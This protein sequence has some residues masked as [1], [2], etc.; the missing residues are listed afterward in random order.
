MAKN[1]R[2]ALKHLKS[3]HK[4][5]KLDEKKQM[6]NEI[7]T[8]NMSGVYSKNPA[9]FRYDPPSPAKRFVP[10]IDG[11]WPSGVPGTP[12]AT[13]YIRPQGYWV[14]DSDWDEFLVP[15]LRVD[16]TESTTNT[17]GFINPET[18]TVK[19]LLPPNSRDFILGPLIDGYTYNHGY[20][21]FTT[22]GYIQK[23]T[24]QIVV[25]GQI[26]GHWDTTSTLP[27]GG[28]ANR[29][30]DG[31]ASQF[32]AYNPKFTLAMAQ[33]FKDKLTAND[34]TKNF[35]YF[36]S[37]GVPQSPLDPQPP[38]SPGNMPGGNV[39]GSGGGGNDP[40]G[41]PPTGTPTG[42]SGGSPDTGSE[43]P[44]GDP[45]G[46][47]PGG[48]NLWGM[49]Q[50][51]ARSKYGHLS[52]EELAELGIVRMPDGTLREMT[53]EELKAERERQMHESARKA[54][55]KIARLAGISHRKLKNIFDTISPIGKML[56][57]LIKGDS[58]VAA[59][60]RLLDPLARAAGKFAGRRAFGGKLETA[61]NVMFRYD[62]W[63]SSGGKKRVDVSNEVSAKE[64]KVLQNELHKPLGKSTDWWLDYYQNK[65][66]PGK[67]DYASSPEE[68]LKI[69]AKYIQTKIDQNM[70]KSGTGL[71]M[72]FHNNVKLD[73]GRY[74]ASGGKDIQM[75]KT[76]KF[77]S[78]GSVGDA[79][80][81]V[82][83]Q[84]LIG[85]GVE[86][87]RFGTG[88]IAK[89]M[90]AIIGSKY[91][92]RNVNRMYGGKAYAAPGMPMRLKVPSPGNVNESIGSF[93]AF[94]NSIDDNCDFL[95]EDKKPIISED[96]KRIIREI[97]QPLKE[98][99][100]LP[101][102]QKLEKYRPNFKGKYK[103]QNTPNVTASKKSDEMVKAKNAAGQTWRTKD[104]YWGGYESQE[105]M[106]VVYDNVGHGDQYWDKI[107]NENLSKRDIKN[108][109]IQEHM[110]IIE[111]EKAMRRLDS[112]FVSPFRN[113]EEQE[114]LDAPKDPLYKKVAK[115]LDKEID[116]PKKPSPKGFPDKAPPELD[117][118]TGMH[119]KYGQRYK[120]D[121][122]D[123]QSAEAM[124][125]QGNPEIDANVQKALD[126][127][128]KDRKVKNLTVNTTNK[129]VD[130]R[131]T[132][133][134]RNVGE[135]KKNF[136][137]L[138][139]QVYTNITTGMKVGQTF[140][141][142]PS[143]QTFTTG[144]ALGGR[145][146][147]PSTVSIFG[148]PTPAP[149]ASSYPLQGYAKPMDMM[150]RKNRENPEDINARLD[151][152]QEFAQ[153]VNSDVMMN[154]RVSD[155]T[156]YDPET[157]RSPKVISTDDEKFLNK[158]Q[159]LVN[160]TKGLG[161]IGLPNDFAQWTIN[162][163]KGDMKPVTKFST[164][165]ERQVRDLVLD[166]FKK[167][168]DATTVDIQYDDYGF[169]AKALPTRLGLG[170]FTATKLDNGK[171]RI[172][173][174]FN[175]DKEFT[176]IGFADIIPGLQ[177][178]ADRLVDI[179]YK[180]RNIKG[181]TDKGGI[182]IDVEIKGDDVIPKYQ[183]NRNK[184]KYTPQQIKNAADR[185]VSV[186]ALV[187]S[188]NR[189][190]EAG[191]GGGLD[192]KAEG[193][194]KSGNWS[195]S[196]YIDRMNEINAAA[197]KKSGPLHK[198]LRELPVDNRPNRGPSK[199]SLALVNA[200]EKI[201]LATDKQLNALWNAWTEYNKIEE[202]PDPKS[203]SGS[204]SEP[205]PDPKGKKKGG[206]GGRRLG[207]TTQRQGGAY[208]PRNPYGTGLD[209][210]VAPVTKKRKKGK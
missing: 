191:K 64:M 78:G 155:M 176:N 38:G 10:D 4:T 94:L 205:P 95:M 89:T 60:D 160:L 101:K 1:F 143:G 150:R 103:A 93:T 49:T 151:A 207:S 170:R 131:E 186:E 67:I 110:N 134:K 210:S 43:T 206:Q 85:M 168:P 158:Q 109:R 24:R 102:T 27:G 152:S 106:N 130:W 13:E 39:P 44:Q 16:F 161:E 163:A 188:Q 17:D 179:S 142:I 63:L 146:T 83:G 57:D 90:T 144:G 135:S 87:D 23:D 6:L 76:Y 46:T 156:N 3:N 34:F 133:Q 82:L 70:T 100:E 173:D 62:K 77:A 182:K 153:N 201:T 47:D 36:Y 171:I 22:I 132:L 73:M 184:S 149:D 61:S 113:I 48:N 79:E 15:D 196:D 202:L 35:P 68:A 104:K 125:V 119:P 26:S 12:G 123:P 30:W 145:E 92:L 59:I 58:G 204:G 28:T 115:R 200:I 52:N 194:I 84:L 33:W 75:T 183:Q 91:G 14:N 72:T 32:T 111:H 136:K 165:M 114:T 8:M 31:T 41:G 25:L 81:T 50:D 148:D 192:S 185:H 159:T 108:R 107:V 29:Q 180:N 175:V 120:Y 193:L 154:A 97:T 37:G 172:Q 122:L 178:T 7:P 137:D 198:K 65:I 45:E 112:T 147:L 74:M 157:Y 19:T 54:M 20:D 189:A 121:K 209:R 177:D 126:R 127:R 203:K 117:P 118:N 53:Q 51:E 66:E 197:D 139:E 56:D 5:T 195:W 129:K 199:A 105:R 187:N 86:L 181:K 98:I 11:N 138:Q 18:G 190:V 174:T 141:H 162:Y 99:K 69:H 40:A 88:N 80:D 116:Y 124:P 21:D 71:S 128:A 9:G 42:G 96:K 55:M 166:K 167:N 169:A 140:K 164:G 208:N 2:R